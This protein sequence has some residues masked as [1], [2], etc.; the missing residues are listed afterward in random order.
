[1][2]FELMDGFVHRSLT[3]RSRNQTGIEIPN[4][5]SQIPNKSQ[6]PISNDRNAFPLI[7]VWTIGIYLLFGACNLVLLQRSQHSLANLRKI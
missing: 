3:R 6:I 1:M 5:K 7:G 4:H 2:P